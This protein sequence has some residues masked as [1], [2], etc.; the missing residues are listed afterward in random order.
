M[1]QKASSQAR[2]LLSGPTRTNALPVYRANL[3][4]PVK[5]AEHGNAASP[6][7]PRDRADLTARR[8]RGRSIGRTE[9]AKASGNALDM[10]TSVWSEMARTQ[11][12]SLAPRKANDDR[13]LSADASR[14]GC[15]RQHDQSDRLPV[16]PSGV[17]LVGR[18]NRAGPLGKLGPYEGL[19]RMKGNFHVRFLEGG[20]QVTARLHSA[21]PRGGLGWPNPPGSFF[22]SVDTQPARGNRGLQG[23]DP[24]FR[25]PPTN[26]CGHFLRKAPFCWAL[27]KRHPGLTPT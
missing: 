6:A 5:F 22:A 16:L 26:I 8:V 11:E 25:L 10:P 15:P 27:S 18:V 4:H 7:R 20:G 1:S 12:E 3:N 13:R 9:E 23:I 2:V 17:K 24:G 19:S 21:W 14:S